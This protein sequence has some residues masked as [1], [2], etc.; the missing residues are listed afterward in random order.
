M[1]S[2]GRQQPRGIPVSFAK[3]EDMTS[4]QKQLDPQLVYLDSFLL[5]RARLSLGLSLG[6]LAVEAEV[7]YRTVRGVV[8]KGGLLPSK[9]R[10][11]AQVLK[12]DV[13]ELLA[14]YDPRFV[15]P[16]PPLGP[17][18][19]STE[20]EAVGYLNQGR[21]APNG[22]YYI[23]CQMQHRHSPAKRGR[24]KFYHLS[25]LSS[26][27]RDAMRNK[28]SR[29]ANVAAEVGIHR[30]VA[31]N[32]TSTPVSD[33]NG[34]WVIDEWVGE[35]T[36]ENH[37]QSEPWPPAQLPRL[38]HE[39]AQGLNALHSANIVARELAPAR[40]LIS[41]RDGHAVLTDFEL[42]KLL[43][44]SPSVSSEWPEDVFL[45]P[46]VDG[47]S[48]TVQSDLYSFGQVAIA[49]AAGSDGAGDLERAP[50]FLGRAGVPKR[51]AKMIVDCLEPVPSNRPPELLPLLTEL[52]RWVEKS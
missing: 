47:T 1:V 30:H 4:L 35:R 13:L 7:D 36:L 15:P 45:A 6:Q 42:A 49:A 16:S 50:V 41:D 2:E 40:V 32:H 34:W 39:I 22:L 44:G 37:L 9:A 52:S 10:D 33:G 3:Q 20:W 27:T 24:G 11:I 18:A 25:W 38:L 29:H 51:L 31:V 46:E 5:D 23:V 8:D 48:A 19:G 26:A 28:L 12:K 43:D 17:L 21:L 14:P